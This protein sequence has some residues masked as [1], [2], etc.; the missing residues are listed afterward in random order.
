MLSQ[1]VS[2]GAAYNSQ[3]R[4][5]ASRCHPGTRTEILNEI[6]GWIGAGKGATKL[7]WL[8]GPAGA[9]KSA[10]A[11]TVAETCAERGQLAASFFFSRS[12]PDRSTLKHL[13]PTI[14]CQIS[15]S[16]PHRHQKLRDILRDDPYIAHRASGS[17]DLLVSLFHDPA[18]MP[19]G[20]TTTSSPFLV[21][22][23]GLD[24]CQGNNDQST[25]LSDIHDLVD[26]HHLPLRFFIT[27]RPESHIQETFDEPVMRRVTEVLSIYGDFL[28]RRDVLA[29]LR[30]E[31]SRIQDSKRHKDIMQFIPKPWP[32]DRVIELIAK[33]SGGYF[34]YAATVIKYVD[35]EYFSCLDRLHQVLGT[36]AA[37]LDP[38]EMPF[39]ELDGLYSNV[40]SRCP[41]SQLPLLKR[42]LGFLQVFTNIQNIEVFLGLRPGQINL[43][44]RGL[45]SIII[46]NGNYRLQSFHASFLDFLFD[47]T[48]AQDY[49]VDIEQWRAN[50]FHRVFSIWVNSSIPVLQ[51][52]GIF[53]VTC[54]KI[55]QV[56]NPCLGSHPAPYNPQQI[57]TCLMECSR[58]YSSDGELRSIIDGSFSGIDPD[59]WLNDIPPNIFAGTLLMRMIYFVR[60]CH[61][62]LRVEMFDLTSI[63]S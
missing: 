60:V 20:Q 47:P 34:I 14:A 3:E 19:P 41:K 30:D 32:S 18:G 29:Y 52:T 7:L 25:I 2:L 45:R 12:S 10:I 8:H 50:N 16:F 23:D 15:M 9:G 53:G 56:Q 21:I 1:W 61:G 27:S 11:Q 36:S 33:K 58:Q 22:I 38:A 48:R 39:A 46:V 62:G 28:A 31:F 54:R 4:F 17:I 35:E 44:L 5:P 6:E 37:H 59:T 49:H 55:L 40:L 24:E 51:P 57:E 63:L 13:F 26:K 43:M 42:V